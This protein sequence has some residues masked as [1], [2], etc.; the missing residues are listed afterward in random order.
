MGRKWGLVWEFTSKLMPHVWS[1]VHMEL[2][3]FPPLAPY[4]PGGGEGWGRYFENVASYILLVTFRQC[5]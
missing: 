1:I 3:E 4:A 5:N 2:D